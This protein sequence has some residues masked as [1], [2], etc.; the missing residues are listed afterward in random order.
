MDQ[1]DP[2]TGA[3][4]ATSP[5][6]DDDEEDDEEEEEDDCH[7]AGGHECQG[8]AVGRPS[9]G[10]ALAA[11]AAPTEG[12]AS[13]IQGDKHALMQSCY[14]KDAEERLL[15]AFGAAGQ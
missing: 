10:G 5:T 13:A 6:D 12:A 15:K 4:A 3:T 11:N 7:H 1:E 14:D 8:G 9:A 2:R